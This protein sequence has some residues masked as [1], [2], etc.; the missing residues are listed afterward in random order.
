MIHN[1][2]NILFPGDVASSYRL[3]QFKI[4]YH[5]V[6]FFNGNHNLFYAYLFHLI[7]LYAIVPLTAT[8][9]RQHPAVMKVALLAAVEQSQY[10]KSEKT[11]D[12]FKICSSNKCLIDV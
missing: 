5:Y 12:S 10:V 6:P 3:V 8:I 4:T 11:Q 7:R 2:Y 9:I 1:Y